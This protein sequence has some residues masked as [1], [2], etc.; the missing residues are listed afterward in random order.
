V[1]AVATDGKTMA[2][3]GLVASGHAVSSMSAVKII[4]LEDGSL[5]GF[6]GDCASVEL[7]KAWFIDGENSKDKPTLDSDFSALVLRKTGKVFWFGEKLYGVEYEAPAAIGSGCEI[8]IGAM[9][10]GLAPAQAVKVAAKRMISVGG[11]ITVLDL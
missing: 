1:T 8:A 5:V 7:A 11:K 4:R 6:S 10:A 9:E 3:D 2:G